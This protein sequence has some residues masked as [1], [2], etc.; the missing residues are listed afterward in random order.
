MDRDSRARLDEYRR[1]HAGPVENTLLD[2]LLSGRDGP[3]RLPA[4]GDRVRP[5][6]GDDRLRPRSARR[7]AAGAR[8]NRGQG[9]RTPQGRRHP[10]TRGPARAAHAR[11]RRR[12]RVLW[13]HGR[14]P[15]AGDEHA[16]PEA[17]AG[18]R[19]GSPTRLPPS[20]RS[21]SARTSSSR[22]ARAFGADDVLATYNRLVDPKSGSQALSAYQGVLS[23][24]GI[25]KVD[26]AHRRVPPRRAERELPLPDEL[27][28]VPGDHP[29]RRLPGGHVHQEAA[30]DGRLPADVVDAGRRRQVRPVP[31]LVGRDDAA[32]R[33]G[34]DL[35]LERRRG[36][37]RAP[38]RRDRPHRPDRRH[39]R[40]EPAQQF[41]HQDLSARAARRT[42]RSRSGST[43]TTHSRTTGCARRSR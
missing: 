13:D 6:G 31:W 9:R 42:G 7:R 15:D 25:K 43:W 12:A 19:A 16:R 30:D 33:R 36:R 26:D 39:E 34:R 28:D 41:R 3:K 14:V 37:C 1:H 2:E 21:S 29:A 10:G 24:G 32:R 17:G 22:A 11:G 18:R 23:P 27:D 8:P 38:R 4:P 20:G 35:L 5:L 40:K